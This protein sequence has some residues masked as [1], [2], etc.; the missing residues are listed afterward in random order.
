MTRVTSNQTIIEIIHLDLVLVI[1]SLLLRGSI[2]NILYMEDNPVDA[3]FLIN[4]PLL[5]SD[6]FNKFFDKRGVELRPCAFFQFCQ[7]LIL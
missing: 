6:C 1:M 7:G 4:F 2:V 3:D 5:F